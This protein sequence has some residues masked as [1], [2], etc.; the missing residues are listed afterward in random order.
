MKFYR[1]K[2]ERNILRTIKIRKFNWIGHMHVLR[3]TSLLKHVMEG[4]IEQ[5]LDVARRR[6]RRSKQIL[7]K[8]K[9]TREY[10]KL[11]KEVL[12]R[13]LWRTRYGR[14]Y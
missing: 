11:E 14:V 13:T 7:D 2:E 12:D 9:E 6:G 4:K 10:W 5:R 3:R 1:V 8:L